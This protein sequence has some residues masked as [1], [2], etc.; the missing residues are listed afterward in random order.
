MECGPALLI[1]EADAARVI[2]AIGGRQAGVHQL[3]QGVVAVKQPHSRRQV[4]VSTLPV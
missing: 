2:W 1:V 4:A 3:V